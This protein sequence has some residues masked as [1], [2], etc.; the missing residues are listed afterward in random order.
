MDCWVEERNQDTHGLR[1]RVTG[2]LFRGESDFQTV[3]IVET[4]GH[5][6]VLLND[7]LYMLSER[8]EFVYH[9][10]IAHVPLLRHP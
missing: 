3:E 6:R 5:G 7:G 1:L 2:V 8:D 10:M 4:A 9:E